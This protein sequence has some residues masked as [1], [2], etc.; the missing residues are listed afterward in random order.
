LVYDIEHPQFIDLTY[1]LVL[2]D[3]IQSYFEL[4]ERQEIRKFA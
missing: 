2:F 4:D 3:Y 1:Y